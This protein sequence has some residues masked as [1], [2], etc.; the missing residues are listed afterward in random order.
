MFNKLPHLLSACK[1]HPQEPIGG[2]RQCEGCR[3]LL[4]TQERGSA[5]GFGVIG[6]GLHE[7]QQVFRW[8]LVTKKEGDKRETK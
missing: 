4:E 5:A 8:F 7:A 3:Q 2:P 1:P 6:P